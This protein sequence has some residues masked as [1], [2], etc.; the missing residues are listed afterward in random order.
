[1]KALFLGIEDVTQ[2]DYYSKHIN[3]PTDFLNSLSEVT[4]PTSYQVLSVFTKH[5]IKLDDLK[6][7]SN[8]KLI[9][10]RSTGFDNIDPAVKERG[11]IICNVPAYG[12]HTVAEFAFGL[13]LSITRNIPEATNRVKEKLTFDQTNLRGMELYGKTIGVIGVGKIGSNVVRMSKGF[14]ME[15]LAFD[16]FKNEDLAWELKFK[17]VDLE[18][19]LKNS[20]VISI[21]CPLTPETKHLINS[22]NVG[23]IKKGAYLVNT[24]RGAV[25]ET[26]ALYGALQNNLAGAALDVLEK[27][28]NLDESTKKLIGLPN[29]LVSPHIAFYTKE[30]EQKIMEETVNN[31]NSFLN[32]NP[33]N[34]T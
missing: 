15:V 31:I 9:A 28:D 10:A 8:V 33:V 24:A 5:K 13:I 20:D 16:K 7:F 30:A 27:E 6:S 25:V 17:Y 22:T 3:L 1:M 29:V 26:E 18:E 21:N 32:G 12:S 11:V 14:G 23:L 34:L 19:L 4:D 2:R